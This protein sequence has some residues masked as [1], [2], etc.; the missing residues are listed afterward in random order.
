MTNTTRK[1]AKRN[2]P[3]ND[4]KLKGNTQ[5]KKG[6]P[7]KSQGKSQ[8]SRKRAND[9]SEDDEISSSDDSESA[10]PTKE[11]RKRQR[12]ERADSEVE[13]VADNKLMGKDIEEVEDGI[14]NESPDEQEVS[15]Y[16]YDNLH[17][18]TIP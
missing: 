8:G 17:W 7:K 15:R 6:N 11:S 4:P 14:G 1:L 16:H 9:S 12:V 18:L 5:R 2:P 13:V 3:K 10:R